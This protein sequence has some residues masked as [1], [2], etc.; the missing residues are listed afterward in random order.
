MLENSVKIPSIKT[1]TD[2]PNPQLGVGTLAWSP[3][4]SYLASKNGLI[5]CW[6]FV[7]N[8]R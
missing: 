3:D 2:K 6:V 4:G 5:T 8:I 1:V 7:N